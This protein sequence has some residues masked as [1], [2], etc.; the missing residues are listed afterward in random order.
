M[1]RRDYLLR[2]MEEFVAAMAQ[3][4]GL[5]KNAQWEEASTMAGAQFQALARTS[6]DELL[7]MSDTELLAQLIQG[8]PTHAVESKIFMLA[9]L[10]KTQGDVL[11]GQGK[12]EESSPYYLKGLHLLLDTFARNEMAKRPDFA[13]TVDAFLIT[14]HDT[15]LPLNTNLMLMRYYE[16]TG[17]LAKAED[18]LFAMVEPE[19]GNVELLNFGI[20]FYQRLLGFTDRTLVAGNLPREEVKA[21]LVELEKL[22]AGSN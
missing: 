20:V 11:A 4:I 6:A 16:Q 13:P 1:L 7:R 8:E 22:K 2:Q 9:T 18:M 19:P 10:F 15:P 17:E 12:F 5:T 3:L 14:L 21:G